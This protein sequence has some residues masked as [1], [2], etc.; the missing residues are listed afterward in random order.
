M[1][2]PELNRSS[3]LHFLKFSQK[4]S[5]CLRN[6]KSGK[7]E[8]KYLT[9]TVNFGFASSLD[10]RSENNGKVGHWT[11]CPDFLIVRNGLEES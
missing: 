9:E 1:G 10:Q 4:T 3:H 5:F 8:T 11:D 6:E 7:R 2:R